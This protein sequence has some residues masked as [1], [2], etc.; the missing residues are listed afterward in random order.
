MSSVVLCVQVCLTKDPRERPSAEQ[1]LQHE[2]LVKQVEAEAASL[3][4]VRKAE[5]PKQNRLT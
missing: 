5:Q 4:E 3:P 1:L 2:W